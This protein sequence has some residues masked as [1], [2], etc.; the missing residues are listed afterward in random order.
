M[1]IRTIFFY[2]Y[3]FINFVFFVNSFSGNTAVSKI[4]TSTAV[5][6]ANI[7]AWYTNHEKSD[8]RKKIIQ[9]E[10]N[11]LVQELYTTTRQEISKH[12]SQYVIAPLP[13]RVKEGVIYKALNTQN[14]P[15]ET[16][17]D[18][19]KMPLYQICLQAIS[20][21]TGLTK[22]HIVGGTSILA[23]GLGFLA[24]GQKANVIRKA[25]IHPCSPF[26]I[27]GTGSNVASACMSD[28]QFKK[29]SKKTRQYIER[30]LQQQIRNQTKQIC[31]S[32]IQTTHNTNMWT[33]YMF[34]KPG[35]TPI[36]IGR[37]HANQELADK[38]NKLVLD[39]QTQKDVRNGASLNLKDDISI[40][41]KHKK[42]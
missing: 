21:E 37:F 19:T 38:L 31:T 35:D 10:A 32:A 23:A 39:E 28:E 34:K 4:A 9:D 15:E 20:N 7:G 8:A 5:S 2:I 6:G 24:Y 13:L 40:Q 42:Q 3:T 22:S 16:S 36:Y 41:R 11:R 30:Q 25:F 27:I 1:H 26:L 33:S 29:C 18:N 14:A 12:A 17:S